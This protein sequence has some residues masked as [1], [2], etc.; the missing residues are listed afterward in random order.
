[1]V[2]VGWSVIVV[3]RLNTNLLKYF[4]HTINISFF[5]FKCGVIDKRHRKTNYVL[6]YIA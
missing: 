5:L 3:G 6:L 2:E 1:M 4:A